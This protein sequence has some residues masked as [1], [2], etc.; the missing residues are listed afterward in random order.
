V[1]LCKGC[2]GDSWSYDLELAHGEDAMQRLRDGL[3]VTL[4][5]QP[6]PTE[7]KLN[8]E[9]VQ[10]AVRHAYQLGGCMVCA[11]CWHHT[12]PSD[13]YTIC[14]LYLHARRILNTD[15]QLPFPSLYMAVLNGEQPHA[16]VRR[17]F[18]HW[19]QIW[20][21]AGEMPAETQAIAAWRSLLLHGA[22]GKPEEFLNRTVDVA[23]EIRTIMR[24]LGIE[25]ESSDTLPTQD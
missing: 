20:N 4:Q 17:I 12:L 14:P 24:Q 16:W 18:M 6:R 8:P 2:G 7:V 3:A 19:T 1:V 13:A 5:T 15:R 22:L 21:T 11:D 10:H 9:Q 23:A 25:D